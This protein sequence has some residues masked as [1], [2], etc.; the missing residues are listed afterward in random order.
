MLSGD[1]HRHGHLPGFIGRM[2]GW[3]IVLNYV[4][5]SFFLDLTKPR[6]HLVTCALKLGS[7]WGGTEGGRDCDA[8]FY[9]LWRL[10]F[11]LR[12]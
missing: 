9:F 8:G 11:A 4:Y 5:F 10:S 2:D 7:L 12:S 1:G 6:P 3:S